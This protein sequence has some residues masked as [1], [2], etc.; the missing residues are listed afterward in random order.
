MKSMRKKLAR[1]LPSRLS[2]VRGERS[3]TEFARELGVFQQNVNRY[4]RGSTP[5]VPFL[6]KLAMTENISLDWLLLG[7]G[8]MKQRRK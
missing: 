7:R 1:E 8:A 2:K 5:H 4:E 3:Q 6:M